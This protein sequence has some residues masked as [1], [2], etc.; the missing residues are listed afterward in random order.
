MTVY[1]PLGI[2]S[3]VVLMGKLMLRELVQQKADWD[4]PVPKKCVQDGRNGEQS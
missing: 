3:P 4:D 1:D 2:V